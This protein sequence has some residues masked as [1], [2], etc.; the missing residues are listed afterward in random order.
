MTDSHTALAAALADRYTIESELG[1][2]GMATV[3]LAYDIKHR[4]KVAIKV[5]APEIAAAFG[6]AR[7]LREI[8]IAAQLQHPHILALFD[9]GEAGGLLYYVMPFVEGE[10]LAQRLQRERQL[11]IDEVV[12]ITR[13]VSMALVHAHARGVIHRDIKP[14]NI[15]LSS[16]AALV[17]DFGIARAVAEAGGERLTSTG[18]SL[19][20]PTYM[21]P[22]QGM[23]GMVDGRSDLYSLACVV[24]E[25]LT[26]EPP[27]TG[28][29][30]QALLAR[31]SIDPV[32]RLR[33]LRTTV[34]QPMEAVIERA[35]AKA[36]A[37]RQSSV[38]EF[39][40]Q[41]ATAAKGGA[42]AGARDPARVG[43]TLL[44]AGAVAL[45]AVAA[46]GVWA[47]LRS[48]KPAP[49]GPP[50]L[51]VLPFESIGRPEDRYIADGMSDEITS[52]MA[53][54]SGLV[55][56]AR[57][58]AAPVA[59]AGRS[60]RDIAGELGVGYLL[61]GSVRTDRR[62]D[63]TGSIRVTPRLVRASDEQV[64]WGEGYDVALA[65]GELL[66]VQSGIA[67]GVARALN[68]SLLLPERAALAA[69]PTDNLS[70]YEAYLRGNA[71]SSQNYATEEPA[72]QAVEMYQRAV[73]ADPKFAM[74]W[75]R[76]SQAHTRYHYFDRAAARLEQA[77]AAAD[78][79]IK[80]DSTLPE[81]H[82][83]LGMMHLLGNLDYDRAQT[84]LEIAQR[85]RPND[86]EVLSY[87]ATLQRRRGRFEESVTSLR[88][89]TER[90]PRSH[91]LALELAVSYVMMRRFPEA[92]REIERV[93][94]LAPDYI[95]GHML[96]SFIQWSWKEDPDK[97]RAAMRQ[98]LQN[99]SM[100]EVLSVIVLRSPQFVLTLGGEFE[101]SLDVMGPRDLSIDPG[102]LY[103]A[104]GLSLKRRDALRSREY[105][106]SARAVW[107]PRART[108]PD[109]MT[110]RALL[111]LS[112]AG[113]GRAEEALREGRIAVG[114]MPLTKDAQLGTY[115][116]TMMVTSAL[117]VDEPDTALVYL[118]P[119]L[120][121]PSNV[122][123]G[124]I[125]I[126]PMFAPLRS[127]PGYRQLIP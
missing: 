107:E 65:P 7:F 14:A 48:R 91:L 109:E 28:S 61:T 113:L 15:L 35:L 25:M 38:A 105:F 98:A 17:A 125:K 54:M 95:P 43:R 26:G 110:F 114:L 58:S 75:A 127:R 22:E 19:G 21:S 103:L 99:H 33:T 120:E 55:V 44:Q 56:I 41:L 92:E 74:A 96:R 100:R 76:L 118:R 101:D 16:D 46:V 53:G 93:L 59:H 83:A 73:T 90:D 8:E 64:I 94:V 112:Y 77:R 2:G 102:F 122:S 82:L 85:G 1:R 88:Q 123:P 106:D 11:P 80:L 20:T 31:H 10:S 50:K 9:S 111:G 81:A 87:L 13:E 66:D 12:R 18:F 89:A 42:A 71:Y 6:V 119:L 72:R 52:R 30:S 104:K 116:L 51:A 36:P 37:D 115:P 47:L 117:L 63:G 62:A 69:R 24:Y 4:R 40:A 126:S 23:G 27:F 68:V 70:A 84:E 108:R 32:P 121:H 34:P 86:S 78:R 3:F 45:V 49:V 57:S 29:T 5:F 124:L 79:A 97:A 39:S 67:D 60:M